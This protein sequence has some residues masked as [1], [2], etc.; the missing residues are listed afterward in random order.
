MPLYF[1]RAKNSN[2]EEEKGY[3][4]AE[5][6]K[7][8]AK[9]LKERGY[10]L[11][12]AEEKNSS[13]RAGLKNNMLSYFSALSGVSLK[14]KLFFTKNL[15]V[16]IKSGVALPRAFEILTNQTKNK[17]FKGVLKKISEKIVKGRPLSEAV[18][19]FPQIFSPL[20]RE[21]LKIGEETG[22]IEDSLDILANQMQKEQ[23]LKSKIKTAMVYPVIVL[24]MAFIIGV[25]MMVFAV[26]KLKKAFEELNLDLPP[27]TKAILSF[28]DF[29]VKEWLLVV[30]LLLGG[31]IL[32]YVFFKSKKTQKLKAKIFISLPLI[33]S[34]VKQSNSALMLRTL[35]SLLKAG[36]PIVRSLSITAGALSNF[37]FKQS[38]K[39]AGQRIQKGEKLSE[40][41]KNY[42]TIYSPLV[43]QMIEVGEETGETPKVL[44]KLAEFYEEEVASATQ[45]LSAVIEPLLIAGLGA[46]V[47]FFAV[48]MLQPMFSIVGKI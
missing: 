25:F 37:Y 16:M 23:E 47:G 22:K 45:R 31:I 42:S 11:I 18:V 10:F 46:I 3:L 2:S 38:L 44:E 33:S 36:V 14:E 39:E 5:D 28:A 21:T 27:T 43:I 6:Q 34:I 17:K 12:Y 19:D 26:P 9:L 8:L 40:I 20:Y 4:E 41:L 15:A 7:T 32:L 48:S 13:Q 1:Y 35:S 30:F 29:L 24:A